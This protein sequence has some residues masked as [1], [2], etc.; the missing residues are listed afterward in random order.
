MDPYSYGYNKVT[1]DSAYLKGADII[2]NLVDIVSKN[3]NF[4]LDIG[5]MA[6]GTIPQIMQTGL[7]DAGKWLKSHGEAIFKTRYWTTA[8]VNGNIRYTTTPDAFYITLLAKPNSTVLI[9]DPIPYLP[10]DRVTVVGGNMTGA[11]VQIAQNA[12]GSYTLSPGAG[13]AAADEYAWVFKITYS[14]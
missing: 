9:K 10:G 14:V 11:A 8:Q 2:Q 4:L 13:V 6:N 1:P 12:N 7:L 3:G 5:P